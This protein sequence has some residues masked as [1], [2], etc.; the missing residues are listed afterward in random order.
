M[1]KL[2]GQSN[3]AAIEDARK[4]ARDTVTDLKV[5]IKELRELLSAVRDP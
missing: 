3:P 4:D 2:A 1:L 5:R